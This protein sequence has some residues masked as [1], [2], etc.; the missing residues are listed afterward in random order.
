M[1]SLWIGSFA[2]M[3]LDVDHIRVHAS[4]ADIFR[5]V[6]CAREALVAEEITRFGTRTAASLCHELLNLGLDAAIELRNASPD[7]AKAIQR[8]ELAAAMAI[9]TIEALQKES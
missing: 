6:V 9:T 8:L 4:E 3:S 2:A 1:S 7:R 5:G